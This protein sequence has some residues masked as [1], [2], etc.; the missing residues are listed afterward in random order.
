MPVMRD[1][2]DVS[3]DASDDRTESESA[4]GLDSVVAFE[5]DDELAM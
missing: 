4:G 1:N 5:G 3:D 2:F